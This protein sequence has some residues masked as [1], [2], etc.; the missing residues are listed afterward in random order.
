MAV[1]GIH[2]WCVSS[3]YVLSYFVG[4]NYHYRHRHQHNDNNNVIFN[5]VRK[6]T[7]G[8]TVYRWNSVE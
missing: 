2:I 5:F 6:T 3:K 8:E 7:V 1:L 4:G